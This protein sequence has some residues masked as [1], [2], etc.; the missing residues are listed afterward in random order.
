MAIAVIRRTVSS[1]GRVLV[2]RPLL[3]VLGAGSERADD[4]GGCYLDRVFVV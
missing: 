1:R 3:L 2:F 4:R